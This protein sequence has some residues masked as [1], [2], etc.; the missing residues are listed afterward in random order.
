M[1]GTALVLVYVAAMLSAAW[2][3]ARADLAVWKF[4]GVVPSEEDL[5][6]YDDF[7][8]DLVQP[9]ESW[10]LLVG[11]D[12]AV[13]D[14]EPDNYS[15]AKYRGAPLWGQL[16]F[17]GGFTEQIDIPHSVSSISVFNDFYLES[18]ELYLDGVSVTIWYDW[19][20]ENQK[21]IT[22]TV[23]TTDVSALSSDALPVHPTHALGDSTKEGKFD[24]HR[25]L[26]GDMVRLGYEPDSDH[27]ISFQTVPEPST[28]GLWA[29]VGMIG[30]IAAWRRTNRV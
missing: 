9:G 19:G 29:I 5:S 25:G 27:L 17:S 12:T 10:V 26:W 3:E 7:Y 6:Y 24:T 23:I 18:E 11:V 20:E 15:R 22:A 1:R 14:E 28:I 8:R 4:S 16:K 30:T 2:G 21:R 13:P